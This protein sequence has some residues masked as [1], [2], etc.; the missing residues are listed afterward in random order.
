MIGTSM[1]NHNLNLLVV[2]LLNIVNFTS[3]IGQINSLT[4]YTTFKSVTSYSNKKLYFF[5]YD[6]LILTL[7]ILGINMNSLFIE[8]H[9]VLW[10]KFG[11]NLFNNQEIQFL[12][13]INNNCQYI[14]KNYMVNLVE[15]EEEEIVCWSP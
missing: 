8:L 11:S 4:Q 3:N 15:E 13:I 10:H 5:Y 12:V 2:I 1:R 6:Y 9:C 14:F 7:K